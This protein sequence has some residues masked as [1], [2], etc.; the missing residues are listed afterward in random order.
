VGTSAALII[1]LSLGLAILYGLVIVVWY[2]LL[3]KLLARRR[4]S[5]S[6][7]RVRHPETAAAERGEEVGEGAREGA[8]QNGRHIAAMESELERARRHYRLA[9]EE[10]RTERD[11]AIAAAGQAADQA[12]ARIEGRYREIDAAFS[13]EE[14]ERILDL[15]RRPSGDERPWPADGGRL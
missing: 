7:A 12:I 3:R 11:A 1:R 5:R 6:D 4:Q 13:D 8:A 15:L 10:A 2:E 9:R 14:T